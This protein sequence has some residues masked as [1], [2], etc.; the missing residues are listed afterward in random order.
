MWILFPWVT[1][2]YFIGLSIYFFA[3][4]RIARHAIEHLSH[5]PV[6]SLPFQT[7]AEE[8]ILRHMRRASVRWTKP[9]YVIVIFT[10]ACGLRA[11]NAQAGHKGGDLYLVRHA[12]MLKALVRNDVVFRR[13]MS[14]DE[15][16]AVIVMPGEQHA[17]AEHRVPEIIEA[18]E[19][20]RETLLPAR[21]EGRF[22]KVRMCP[23]VGASERMF[24]ADS[25]ADAEVSA[26]DFLREI[27]D[28]ADKAMTKG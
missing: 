5:D 23:H 28:Q 3:K 26:R 27:I 9:V 4:L 14:S 22:F 24:L 8:T 20:P 2:A 21:K 6:T 10:D 19:T 13:G 11:V 7:W 17:V 18:L 1:T 25:V 12:E 15:L 16:V